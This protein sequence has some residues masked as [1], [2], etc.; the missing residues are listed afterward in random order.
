MHIIK[1]AF[2]E[3]WPVSLDNTILLGNW[4]IKEDFHDI[5]KLKKLEVIK[6]HFDDRKK[7]ESSYKEINLIYNDLLKLISDSL[8]K[9]F[10]KNN[11]SRYWEII[12][13]WWL[14]TYIL[15]IYDR[16]LSI[17]KVLQKYPNSIT[18]IL[19]PKSYIIS[20][21]T[22]DYLDNI[23]TDYFNFQIYSSL[24][25][26]KNGNVNSIITTSNSNK[27]LT[28]STT[29]NFK[30]FLINF[31]KILFKPLSTQSSLILFKTG[32]SKKSLLKII[33][34]TKFKIIPF[35]LYINDKIIR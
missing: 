28:K 20:H 26:I 2:K 21:N 25:K 6:Y 27:N 13:G 4:C 12:Y 11:D 14:F 30:S 5:E 15:V 31:L 16:N 3:S 35:E 1:T 23:Q 24:W 22:R 29:L 33:I 19:N 9:L 32:F 7:I 18:N 17:S 8:N 10:N 34:G